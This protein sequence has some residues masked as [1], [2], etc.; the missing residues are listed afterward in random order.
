MEHA[1]GQLSLQESQSAAS[2]YR[3]AETAVAV[4]KAFDPG[5]GAIVLEEEIR[6]SVI[7]TAGA[8]LGTAA[9]YLNSNTH[10]SLN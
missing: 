1:Q 4:V 5:S 7:N 9:K 2:S 6:E 10:I 8:A 3:E